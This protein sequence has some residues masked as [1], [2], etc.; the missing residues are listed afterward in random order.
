MIF[1]LSL[2]PSNAFQFGLR[3]LILFSFLTRETDLFSLN[4]VKKRSVP[5]ALP[6]KIQISVDFG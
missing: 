1:W 5:S 3:E 4:Y 2:K 6:E